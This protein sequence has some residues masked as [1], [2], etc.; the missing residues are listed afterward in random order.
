MTDFVGIGKLSP[1]A[2]GAVPA[3]SIAYHTRDK[4]WMLHGWIDEIRVVIA[5][6]G[7]RAPAI[8]RSDAYGDETAV[9][10]TEWRIEVDPDTCVEGTWG[11][12]N[13]CAF[14]SGTVSGF[15]ANWVDAR[16]SRQAIGFRADGTSSRHQSG[17][18]VAMARRWRIVA[19]GE[20]DPF[21]ICSF[22]Q[23]ATD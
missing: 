4:Q 15:Y 7:D 16:F 20:R 3:G 17:E 6:T 10:I 18:P 8:Y 1:V 2:A 19:G 21:V 11:P 22:E 14:L 5:L 9:V 12:Q 13:G 23:P